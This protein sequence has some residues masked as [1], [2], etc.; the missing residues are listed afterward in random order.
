MATPAHIRPG[1]E[2]NVRQLLL[3]L[4]MGS[5]NATM[6]IQYMFIAPAATDPS[7]P[8][9]IL[10]TKALQDGLCAAGADCEVTGIVGPRTAKC[11]AKLVGPRW[12]Q[13]SWYQLFSAVI[14]AKDRRSFTAPQTSLSAVGFIPDLPE[15]PG[16]LMT[17]ALMAAGA[18]YLYKKKS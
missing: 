12:N 3:R 11:L 15:I 17:I 10:M 14:N 5:Y 8:S 6:A 7:M 1:S 9:I 4:G 2:N 16:G 18:Y 13:M